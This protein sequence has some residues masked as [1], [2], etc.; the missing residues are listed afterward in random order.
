MGV[1]QGLYAKR[2]ADLARR[3]AGVTIIVTEELSDVWGEVENI[4]PFWSQHKKKGLQFS[5]TRRR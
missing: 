2:Q 1:L 4:F 5:K 3:K